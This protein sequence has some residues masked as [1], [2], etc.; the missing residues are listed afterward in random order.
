MLLMMAIEMLLMASFLMLLMMVIENPVLIY[1]T[2]TGML[3]SI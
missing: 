1:Y 3:H 2:M